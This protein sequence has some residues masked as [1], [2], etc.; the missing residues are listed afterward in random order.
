IFSVNSRSWSRVRT[1]KV[2]ACASGFAENP[3]Y[4]TIGPLLILAL[5]R[6]DSILGLKD[7]PV[8]LPRHFEIIRCLLFALGFSLRPFLHFQ[9]HGFRNGKFRFG[10]EPLG[11]DDQPKNI[12]GADL[13]RP[14]NQRDVSASARCGSSGDVVEGGIG[15][16]IGLYLRSSVNHLHQDLRHFGVSS[17]VVGLRVFRPVPQTDPEYLV[18]AGR[19]KGDF[20]PESLLLAKERNDFFFQRLGKLGNGGFQLHGDFACEHVNLLGWRA[21]GDFR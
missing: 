5:S 17:A 15:N 7:S 4:W 21:K 6:R 1:W 16:L 18:S 3:R 2:Y 11:I 14:P 13:A 12:G 8:L 19:D 10:V 20:V 9:F